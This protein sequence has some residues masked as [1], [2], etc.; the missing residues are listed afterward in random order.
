MCPFVEALLADSS[1][2]VSMESENVLIRALAVLALEVWREQS[3]P[4]RAFSTASKPLVSF[5]FLARS[6]DADTAGMMLGEDMVAII[7]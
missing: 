2:S 7:L 4:D 5:G 3:L 1:F 6:L